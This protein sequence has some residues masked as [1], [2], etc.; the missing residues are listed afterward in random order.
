M[1]AATPDL[2]VVIVTHNGCEMAL[3]T[4]RSARA[5]AG[6]A[7]VQ[8]IVAD[9]ESSDGTPAAIEAEFDDVLVLRVP[10]RGF[11]AGNNAGIARARGRYI[12][13]L[14]PDV[15]IREGTFG[16]LVAALDSRPD[17]GIASVVQVGT[18]GQLQYSMRRFP[19]PLRDLGE[20][21]F[22]AHWPVGGT[23]QELEMRPELYRREHSPDWVVGAFLCARAEAVAKI[24]PLD[25]R[26]FLYSEEIDWCKRAHD[27]GWDV[28]H[29]PTMTVIHH[30]GRRD[31]GDLMAQLAYSR[32]L[33]AH[34]HNGPLRAWAIRA[35]LAV[36]YL[37]RIATSAVLAPFRPS[38]RRRLRAESRAL[39]VLLGR[40]EPPLRAATRAGDARVAPGMVGS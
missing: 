40:A 2:S 28:R 16:D 1:S 27:A 8:W 24:G 20:S 36:G 30:A 5:A 31:G 39:A 25:E 37:A 29:L 15:E 38:A 35:A 12:L 18:D 11:A 21:L 34:K 6:S 22:A 23:L 9:S 33:Y 19:S 14:N 3:R 13:L 32:T 17:V 10:N 26:F 4:L 7:S